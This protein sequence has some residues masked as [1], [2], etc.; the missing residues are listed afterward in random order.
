MEEPDVTVAGEGF[1]QLGIRIGSAMVFGLVVLAAVLFGEVW[2]LGLLLASAAALG[3]WE[4]T[5]LMGAEDR[6][7]AVIAALGAAAIVLAAALGTGTVNAPAGLLAAAGTFAA[8]LILTLAWLVVAKGSTMNGAA[9]IMVAAV[10]IGFGLAHLILLRGVPTVGKPL[11]L[12]TVLGVWAGDVGA[13]AVG[14][15][16]GRHKLAPRL[17]PGKSWEGFIAG[18]AATVAVWVLLGGAIEVPITIVGLAIA[19]VL[20]GVFGLLGDLAESRMKRL[21][22]VK[23]SGTLMPGHGGIL[24]RIDS[25]ILVSV[26]VFWLAVLVGLA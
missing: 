24:D 3:G 6:S 2:G 4:L 5:R 13:Y 7:P 20:S 22:G 16:I 26:A 15:A 17:S 21:A 11:V 14:V 1:G 23:D 12:L 19:G 8:V 10:W 9:G 25:L 18:V